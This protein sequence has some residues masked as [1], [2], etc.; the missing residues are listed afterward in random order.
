MLVHL[1]LVFIDNMASWVAWMSLGW[2]VGIIQ[3]HQVLS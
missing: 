3:A 2:A 1:S